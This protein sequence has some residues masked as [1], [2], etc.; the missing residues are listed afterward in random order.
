[1]FFNKKMKSHTVIM[2]VTRMDTHRAALRLLS[3]HLLHIWD[4]HSDFFC[5][6]KQSI[7]VASELSALSM[8]PDPAGC[9][10][11]RCGS[12]FSP[13]ITA[14]LKEICSDMFSIDSPGA[15][16]EI[17]KLTLSMLDHWLISSLYSKVNISKPVNIFGLNAKPSHTSVIEKYSY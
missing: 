10:S 5:T 15:I 11:S 8:W 16:K 7:R 14:L 12:N 4:F 2:W 9:P 1:M 6:V 13:V 17:Q 3:N